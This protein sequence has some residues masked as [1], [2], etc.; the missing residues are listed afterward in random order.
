LNWVWY[1]NFPE[2]SPEYNNLMTDSKGNKHLFTMPIG[3]IKPDVWNTQKSYAEEVLPPQFAE[4]VTKTQH[5]FVQAITDVKAS[6]SVFLGDKVL[7]LGD[8][9]AGFRPHTAASTAQAAKDAMLLAKYFGG[10]ISLEVMEQTMLEYATRLSQSGI[11]MGTRSQFGHH[12]L[13][14]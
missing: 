7:M 1:W 8:A 2:G 12:P 4:L 3:L 13:S 11:Q 5:P 6:K 10:D 9:I 14:A